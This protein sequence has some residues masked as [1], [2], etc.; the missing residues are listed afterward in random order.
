MDYL[1][2]ILKDNN[3]T[4]PIDIGSSC[5]EP[6]FSFHSLLLAHQFSC[7]LVFIMRGKYLLFFV[8]LFALFDFMG[9]N[10]GIH[11]KF[12]YSLLLPRFIIIFYLVICAEKAPPNLY[13]C[14]LPWQNIMTIK[15]QL[16]YQML[17]IIQEIVTF[18]KYERE[19]VHETIIIYHH[20]G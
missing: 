2:N 10:K 5:R 16:R 17:Y 15:F 9:S 12:R 4:P 7:L 3:R 13:L 1:K 20:H 19:S 6:F 11:F 14:I 8:W 18:L